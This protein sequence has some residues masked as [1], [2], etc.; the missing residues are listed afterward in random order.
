MPTALFSQIK[1][2]SSY[3]INFPIC[4]FF[5]GTPPFCLFQSEF[6][7]IQP[8]DQNNIQHPPDGFTSALL[9][10]KSL[11]LL[12][13]K[14]SLALLWW[15]GSDGISCWWLCTIKSQLLQ[16]NIFPFVLK[17]TQNFLYQSSSYVSNAAQLHVIREIS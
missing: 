5:S 12:L 1:Q 4:C 14:A 11:C 6:T 3:M 8:M 17:V 16:L 7:F 13:P 9:L 10:L 2:D 15:N